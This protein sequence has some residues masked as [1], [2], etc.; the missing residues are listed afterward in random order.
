MPVTGKTITRMHFSRLCLNGSVAQSVEQWSEEPRVGS[1][2]LSGSTNDII[3]KQSIG[4][5]PKMLKVRFFCFL[6]KKISSIG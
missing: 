6:P 5:L 2:I 4:L 1:S 3:T